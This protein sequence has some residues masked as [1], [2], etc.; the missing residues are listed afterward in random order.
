VLSA[1]ALASYA[2]AFIALGILLHGWGMLAKHGLESN[3]DVPR[4]SKSL[5]WLCWL[6]LGAFA[7]WIA[8]GLLA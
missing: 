1:R 6:T 5:Y 4:W 7:L 8:F 2:L 3:A